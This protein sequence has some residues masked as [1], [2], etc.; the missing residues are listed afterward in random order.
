ML[1]VWVGENPREALSELAGLGDRLIIQRAVEDEFVGGRARYE[2]R[3]DNQRGLRNYDS[4]LRNG[5]RP[6]Q[7]ADRWGRARGGDPAGPRGAEPFASKCSRA[8]TKLLRSE[9]L[10]AMVIGAFVSGLSM[11]DVE[12]L[13]EQAGLGK[14]SKSFPVDHW[15]KLR[16]TNPLERFNKEI[17]RRTDVV[18][19]FPDDAALIRLVRMLCIEQNDESLVGRRS[20]I[21]NSLVPFSGLQKRRQRIKLKLARGL[22]HL[23]VKGSRGMGSA[24]AVGH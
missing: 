18:G 3:P 4:G 13:C 24:E 9:R 16:S 10:R 6:P 7:A 19:I 20:L 1:A 5:F 21:G 12:S 22:S 11:R 14:L 17:G 2:R 15:R 8:G 23:C